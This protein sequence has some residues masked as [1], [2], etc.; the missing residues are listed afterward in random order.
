MTRDL[1]HDVMQA[2]R[3]GRAGIAR[4]AEEGCGLGTRLEIDTACNLESYVY[5]KLIQVSS[6]YVSV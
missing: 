2:G 6:L 3:A 5:A 4:E 1:Y